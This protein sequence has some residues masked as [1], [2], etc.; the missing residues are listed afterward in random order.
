MINSILRKLF[1]EKQV[2]FKATIEL[3]PE[4]E[5]QLGLDQGLYKA[6]QLKP[7]NKYC[8]VEKGEVVSYEELEKELAQA[9]KKELSERVNGCLDDKPIKDVK[10]IGSD[11]RCIE[12]IFTVLLKCVGKAVLSGIIYD[13]IK[14]IAKKLLIEKLVYR[15]G[16]FFDIDVTVILPSIVGNP[17]EKRGAFFYYLLFSNL[18]LMGII[19][20]LLGIMLHFIK[21]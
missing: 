13:V 14:H 15:Y 11:E 4:Y 8:F 9:I 7:N 12:I 21:W 1:P 2:A 6:Y 17:H 5:K 20:G 16:N 3:T 10:V 19:L 18:F